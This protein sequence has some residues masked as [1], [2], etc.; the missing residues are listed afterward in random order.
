[1][2]LI[3]K[4]DSNVTVDVVLNDKTSIQEAS[5]Y[6]RIV[7]SPGPGLPSEAGIMPE[8]LRRLSATHCIFG[9]CLGMQAIGENFGS[10]LKNLDTVYHGVATPVIITEQTPMY[11]DCPEQ[12][13][14][15]RYHSWVLDPE[16]LSEQLIVTA[17]D[18]RKNI[19]SVRHRH[20]RVSGVQ[21]HPESIL[22]EFGE[23][24][25]RNWLNY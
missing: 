7:L 6:E 9:V 23:Q 17:M 11:S 22:S 13:N 8:L 5:T 4:V 20:L 24:I 18:E 15:G 2:H 3:E 19:M 12:F 14:V 25:I 10:R 16:Q 1:M 21:F